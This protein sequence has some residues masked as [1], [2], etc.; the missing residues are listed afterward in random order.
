MYYINMLNTIISTIQSTLLPTLIWTIIIFF[1]G[2]FISKKI[3]ELTSE[4]LSKFKLNQAMKNLNWDGFLKKHNA[5]LDAERF[6]GNIVKIFFILLT[7]MICVE[8]L[9]LSLLSEFLMQIVNYYPNIFVSSIMFIIAVFI[10]DFSRKIIFI[11]SDKNSFKYSN[12]IGYI[13]SACVWVLSTLAILYQLKIV[14]DLILTVFI[15]VVGMFALIFGIAF[16]LG[17]VDLVKK[18]LKDVYKNSKK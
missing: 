10:A 5:K 11:S 13:I 17:G 18:Y 12:S 7:L 2:I 6:F 16:G 15:G 1:L 3:G 4:G 14:P 8:I 9:N